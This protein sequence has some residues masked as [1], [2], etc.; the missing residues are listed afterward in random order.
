MDYK[1]L[2]G[3]EG[4]ADNMGG[5]KQ[6]F[7]F[8]RVSDFL[9]IK[10]VDPNATT[11]EGLVEITGTHTFNGTSGFHKI[12]CTMDKGSIDMATQGERD[13]RSYKQMGKYFYPGSESEIHGFASQA[14][15]DQFIVLSEMPDGKVI[16]IGSADFYAEILGHFQTGTNST[17]IRGYEFSVESMA[18]RNYIYKGT[19]TRA[20]E[21]GS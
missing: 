17:G 19:I 11:L 16:Q 9:S 3:P 13:G 10:T 7:Y 8:A 20:T 4:G 12:Y 15:N 21:P 1:S 14:K 5:T 18:P 6:A 2:T